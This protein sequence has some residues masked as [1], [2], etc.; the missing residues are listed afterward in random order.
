MTPE[1]VT[2]PSPPGAAPCRSITGCTEHEIPGTG[3]CL[4][5]A[6]TVRIDSREIERLLALSREIDS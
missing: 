6:T 2:I 4:R 3:R 1:A 5:H